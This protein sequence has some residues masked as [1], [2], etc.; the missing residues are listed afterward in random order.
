MPVSSVIEVQ[1]M[2]APGTALIQKHSGG[3]GITIVAGDNGNGCRPEPSA[4]QRS[5]RTGA[6]RRSVLTRESG[7]PLP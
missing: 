2:M 6:D 7:A 3:D 1:Y 4:W 5:G